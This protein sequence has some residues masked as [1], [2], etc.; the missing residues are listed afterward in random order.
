MIADN[1]PLGR[2]S[3]DGCNQLTTGGCSAKPRQQHGFSITHDDMV[4]LWERRKEE[5]MKLSKEE[6]VELLIGKKEHI[7]MLFG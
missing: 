2:I 5:L 3:C 1:C 4:A 6:L 7:G